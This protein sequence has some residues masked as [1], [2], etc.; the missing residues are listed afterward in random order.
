[1]RAYGD[2]DCRTTGVGRSP[3][4]GHGAGAGTGAASAR[5]SHTSRASA[6]LVS[7][8]RAGAAT[9]SATGA[10]DEGTGCSTG[11]I[12]VRLRRGV[13][14]PGLGTR[15]SPESGASGPAR[16]SGSGWAGSEVSFSQGMSTRR[17]VQLGWLVIV[18]VRA[19]LVSR[20]GQVQVWD[21][22]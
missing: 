9:C 19:P 7:W 13:S 11:G 16:C 12:W 20:L 2:G 3:G 15:G 6:S 14:S 17:G 1:G 10:I 5:A 8:S 21:G 22:S 4:V 18:I